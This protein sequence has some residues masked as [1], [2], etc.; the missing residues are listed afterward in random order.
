MKYNWPYNDMHSE[1]EILPKKTFV[2]HL[3]YFF[4]N[5]NDTDKTIRC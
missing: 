5:F 3:S 2:L 4:L 1:K